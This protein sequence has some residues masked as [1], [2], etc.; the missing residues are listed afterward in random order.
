MPSVLFVCQGN[1]Y[2]SVAAS[3][4]FIE[5][6]RRSEVNWQQWRVESAGTWARENLP[7]TP[8]MTAVMAKRGLDVKN[9]RSRM[10]SAEILAAFALILAMES[11]Q[12]EA[13]QI[14]FPFAARRV[15]LLTEM[16]GAKVEINDPFDTSVMGLQILCNQ[17]DGW[18]ERGFQRIL[19]LGRAP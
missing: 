7:T 5:K 10:V 4:I 2:R 9:H 8:E 17:I 16:A 12:K 1:L 13:L 3:A 11:G 14:E 6:L 15:Y 18:L 19:E